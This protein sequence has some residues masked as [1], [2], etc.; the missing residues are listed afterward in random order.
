M[1]AQIHPIY[2]FDDFQLDPRE[3]RLLR[4][5]RS[6]PLHGKAFELLFVLIRNHGRL[7]TKDE[8]FSMVWPDQIVEESNLTVNMSAIRRALGERASS[9]RYIA[10]V[11][12]RGYRFTGEVRELADQ[13]LTIERESFRRVV[14]EQNECDSESGTPIAQSVLQRIAKS[15]LAMR[16]RALLL[17]S[18]CAMLI[19]AIAGGSLWLLRS[20]HLANRA[21]V[22][23][24]PMTLHR[25]A[26]HGGTPMRA[27][28]SPDGKSLVY[29]Q[30]INGK[31]SLWLGQVD[32]NSS[33][34]IKQPSDLSYF[35]VV[36]SP[37]GGSIYITARD[38]KWSETKLMRMPVLGGVMTELI[39]NVDS[40]V[41]FSPDDRRLAFLRNDGEATSIIIADADDGK[42]ERTLLARK[43][44]ENFSSGGLAWSPD[45]KRIAVGANTG[46][47][48]HT[49]IFT[50]NIADGGVSKISR[51]SW[52]TVGNLTWLGEGNGLVLMAREAAVA[53]RSQLWLV[54]YPDGEAQKLTN[55]LNIYTVETLS[56]SANGTL[57]VLQAHNT[58]EIWVAPHGEVKLA[59]RALQGVEP[60]YEGIDGLAWTPD[61]RLLYSAYVGD[62]Q[63]IWEMNGDGTDLRQLTVNSGD[64]VDR[65]MSV[66]A[67]G[68]YLVFQSNRSGSC[69]IWRANTDGSNLE[70][71]TSG[72]NN[73]RPCLSP[74]GNWIIYISEQDGKS[75]LWRVSI[76][77]EGAKQLTN[78]PSSGP[79]VSPDGKHIAYL[80]SS[81][82]LPL[83]IAIIPFDGG[84]PEKSFALPQRPPVT[85]ARRMRWSP[86]GTAL[87]Y[88]DSMQGLWRQRLDQKEPE[89]IRDFQNMVIFQFAWSFDG[90]NLAYTSAIATRDIILLDSIK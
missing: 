39:A 72:G 74:D 7:L 28:I 47:Q 69:H 49:A 55:D 61:G 57:A 73:F 36:F 43:R 33:V 16:F 80:E 42:N 90:K 46:D 60:R 59:Q 81:D 67:D 65:E 19:L 12:G 13:E 82:S 68:R 83:H 18:T 22:T 50:V 40:P 75:T 41:T 89:P 17:L 70:Q 21:A 27:V 62:G 53:R 76:D 86:D 24:Q 1:A 11:S 2:E 56:R 6:V 84:R 44:P 10:T 63:A 5:G 38:P 32:A 54:A 71:L 29:V 26:T 78:N 20:A 37:D 3:R 23:S 45:G 48:E 4:S 14:V 30:R 51:R 79:Q 15:I 35:A 31:D 77:G 87:I 8:I 85:L 58:S 88:K 64:V 9:P 66:T 52:G 34:L 25:F